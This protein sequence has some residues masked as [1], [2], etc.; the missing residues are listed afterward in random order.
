MSIRSTGLGVV[1]HVTRDSGLQDFPG[2]ADV[3][4]WNE[5]KGLHPL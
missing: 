4:D 2:V 1:S 3:I 5:G